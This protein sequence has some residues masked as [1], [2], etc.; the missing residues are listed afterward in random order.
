MRV[1]ELVSPDDRRPHA[2]E[3]RSTAWGVLGS[4][5]QAFPDH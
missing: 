3:V 1:W 5:V 2:F 4:L